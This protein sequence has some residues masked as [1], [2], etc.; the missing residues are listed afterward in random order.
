MNL[1]DE[2]MGAALTGEGLSSELTAKLADA[3]LAYGLEG[4]TPWQMLGVTSPQIKQTLK[5]ARDA[6][7]KNAYAITGNDMHELRRLV[8]SLPRIHVLPLQGSALSILFEANKI[9]RLPASESSLYE[10]VREDFPIETPNKR[11]QNNLM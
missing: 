10:I 3:L 6:A 1:F 8:K 5:Q 9:W 11:N 4:G 2:A 7:I